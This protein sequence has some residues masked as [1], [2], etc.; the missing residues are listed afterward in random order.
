MDMVDGVLMGKEFWDM[1]GGPQAYEEVLG[2]Y[3]EVGRDKG[4]NML[5]QLSL[6]Y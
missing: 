2:I 5:D 1:I 3:Q 4:P 6:G